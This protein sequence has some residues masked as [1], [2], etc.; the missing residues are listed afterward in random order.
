MMRIALMILRSIIAF[1]F[2]LI[3]LSYM[4]KHNWNLEKSYNYLRKLAIMANRKGR[5]TIEA[6]GVENIPKENGFVFFPNHQGMYDVMAFL[7]SSPNPFAFVAKAELKNVPLLK[8]VMGALHSLTIDR[9]DLRQSVKVI[10]EIADRVSK[11]ENFL[12]FAEGTR[13]KK[14]NVMNDMK[15]GSFKCAIKAKA[16][17]VPCAIVDAFVPFD[18]NSIK[19]VTVKIFYLEPLYYEDYKDMSSLE[20]ATLVKER[21]QAVLDANS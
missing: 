1:P 2:Y 14:G 6:H 21:I 19:K 11:G 13:S 4:G 12:I 20:I 17:I 9:R 10:D 5:V 7:D 8:Q 3:K 15:G 18:V 16:P